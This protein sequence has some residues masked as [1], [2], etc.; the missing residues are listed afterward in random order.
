MAFGL[1][2]RVPFLDHRLVE[3]GLA[4]PDELKI[5]TG[6]GK[7][8]LKRW[9][10]Q[11]LPKDHLYKK[12]RGFH[13]PVRDWFTPDFLFNLKQKLVPNEAIKTWF[14]PKVVSDM[15]AQQQAG[16][17]NTRELFCLMQF[18]IWH[19]LFIDRPGQIPSPEEN[20]LDWL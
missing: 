7:L 9:A 3:F 14:N 20:P 6:Q 5:A 12:K 15:I 17:N 8:F 1:E 11:Y 2:A 13:V 18:A 19:R 16:K 4:L 10:E